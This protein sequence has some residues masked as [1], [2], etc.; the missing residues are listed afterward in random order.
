MRLGEAILQLSQ[1]S[2]RIFHNL[3]D[4]LALDG[5]RSL[6]GILSIAIVLTLEVLAG[7]A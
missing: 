1:L 4:L 5:L 7:L 6:R 2:F 3:G